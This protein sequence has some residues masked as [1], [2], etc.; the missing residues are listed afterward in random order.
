[1]VLR[2]PPSYISGIGGQG[3]IPPLTVPLRDGVSLNTSARE[4]RNG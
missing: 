3:A 1:L 4:Y 2:S